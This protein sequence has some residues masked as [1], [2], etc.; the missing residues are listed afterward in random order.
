MRIRF[1]AQLFAKTLDGKSRNPT[2]G[3][4]KD[5]LE[6]R[7]K[8]K[9]LIDL[10]NVEIDAGVFDPTLVRYKG[11][12]KQVSYVKKIEQLHPDIKLLDLWLQCCESQVDVKETTRAYWDRQITP[13]IEQIPYGVYKSLE[14]KEWLLKEK[15]QS[16]AKRVLGQISKAYS[17][18]LKRKLV[19]GKN[20]YS[21]LAKELKHDYEKDPKPNPFTEQEMEE[22]ICLF[23]SHQGNNNGRGVVGYGYSH[24]AP[25]VE[26]LFLTGCRPSELAGLRRE[27]VN[28]R[29]ITF[30]E[31]V[32]Y[33]GGSGKLIYSKGSKNNKSRQFPINRRLG[34]LLRDYLSSHSNQYVFPSPKGKAINTNNFSNNAWKKLVKPLFPSKTIYSC[35]DTFISLQVAKTGKIAI[36]AKWCDTSVQVIERYY[37]DAMV[38]DILPR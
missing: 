14:I 15:T 2:L 29:Y 27:N 5:T 3:Q 23:K 4:G 32:V 6:N 33:S 22:V 34:D 21:D 18:G 7:G 28:E 38:A 37:L 19:K 30:C 11:A 24:Y 8:A 35:R 31:S 25:F 12:Y 10:I 26:A 9:K 16:T 36:I 1:P 20:P 17:W 13:I